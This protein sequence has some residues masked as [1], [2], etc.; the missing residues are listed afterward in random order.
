MLQRALSFFTMANKKTAPKE[1]DRDYVPK[2]VIV[3][4]SGVESKR[5]QFDAINVAHQEREFAL[6]RLGFYVGYHIVIERDGTVRRARQDLERDC[7]A[8]GRNFDSLSVCLAGNCDVIAPTDAQQRALAALLSEW[9]RKYRIEAKDIYPHRHFAATS[10][11]GAKCTDI[12][13]RALFLQYEINRLKNA[14]ANVGKHGS[15]GSA[16]A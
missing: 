15:Y 12:M 9:C 10:C 3:H 2:Y 8:L 4:H 5:P 14:V 16:Q 6:S 7:D 1:I 13:P 11:P